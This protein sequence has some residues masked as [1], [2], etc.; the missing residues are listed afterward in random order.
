MR[1]ILFR[2]FST[3]SG[4]WV[5]G[6]LVQ[7]KSHT[8][9]IQP[10]WYNDDLFISLYNIIDKVDPATVGQF[11]GLTDKNGK[12]IFEGDILQTEDRIVAVAWHNASACWDSNFIRYVGEERWTGILNS[13]WGRWATVIG[14]IHD[15]PE[16]LEGVMKDA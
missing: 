9:I 8:Y 10:G 11:T 7:T 16:L 14:N 5:E 15:N 12:K 6:F 3:D 1:E 13:Q 2:G 4:E